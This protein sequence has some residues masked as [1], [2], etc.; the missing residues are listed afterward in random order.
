[1][2]R[3]KIDEL[4]EMGLSKPTTFE[5]A[6][7][8]LNIQLSEIE[9]IISILEE[10]GIVK[11]IYSANPI[12]PPY[13]KT[14]KEIPPKKEEKPPEGIVDIEYKIEDKEGYDEADVKIIFLDREKEYFY[15]IRQEHIAPYTEI[16]LAKIREEISLA[17]PPETGQMSEEEKQERIYNMQK[18][19]ADEKLKNIVKDEK[20]RK[21]LVGRTKNEM[22]G[23]GMISTLLLDDHLEEIAI[24]RATI[25]IA[26]FHKKYGWLQTNIR[27]KNDLHI[28]NYASQIARRVGRQINVLNPLL[29]AYLPTGD[30]V[31]ATIKPISCNGATIS[32]RRFAR[33]P[34]TIT[35]MV[36]EFMNTL[37]YEM[38][39][40]L[41]Q[42]IQYEM[43]VL[44]AGGTAS[45]K[46]S[47]LNGLSMLFQP[48]H[49]IISIEDTR[50]ITLPSSHWNWVA[51]VSRLPNSEGLG[52]VTM[53]DLMVNSLRMRPD[54]IIVGEIRRKE[55][56]RTLFEAMHTG[57][58]VYSTVH[59]DTGTQLVR[60]LTEPPIE[61]P[62]I[63]LDALH[64][65]VVQ[66]RDR[67]RNIRRTLEI[68]EVDTGSGKPE[69]KKIYL[70]KSRTDTFERVRTPIKYID[71]LNVHTGMTEKEFEEDINEKVSILKYLVKQK[72]F[73][74]EEVGKVI[75]LYYTQPDEVIKAV[76]KN[77]KIEKLT[78]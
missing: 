6:A 62:L 65:I 53:L 28:V 24:N 57:H 13:Y 14:I 19:L 4:V 42:A 50:E 12:Q 47:M 48:F 73:N 64:V 36:S 31:N 8:K 45:G 51:L 44:V 1:M 43:N 72:A 52:E 55:E 29:D 54:R 25:P 40:F 21:L 75:H 22:F 37:S 67:R 38:A 26:V 23:L 61:V 66:Y 78:G 35:Q 10:N 16:Y 3:T 18:K 70:W 71:L 74:L 7:S 2:L 60:R 46:T 11:T 41:W 9:K 5:E 33:N 34:W 17:L 27:L 59:A 49:R 77:Y 76:E 58:S 15:F 56:A 30:R 39:A 68:C 20:S 69:V 32:I 63:E